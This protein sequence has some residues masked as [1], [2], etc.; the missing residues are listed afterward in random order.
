M[1]IK[2]NMSGQRKKA[3]SACLPEPKRGL[4]ADRAHRV[5]RQ[6]SRGFGMHPLP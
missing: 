4:S 2:T 3:I 6:Q 1:M 5:A